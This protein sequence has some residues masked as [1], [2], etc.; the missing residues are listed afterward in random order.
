MNYS[1]IIKSMI[2]GQIATIIFL[3]VGYVVDKHINPNISNVIALI[4]GGIANYFMQ[5]IVFKSK[6]KFN[7]STI[8]KFIIVD[9]MLYTYEELSFIYFH[10]KFPNNTLARLVIATIGFVFIS[11]PLRKFYAF[12][13]NVSIIPL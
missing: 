9:V 7:S 13:N 1:E 12:N 2:G 4:C 3:I 8:T 11:F 10:D 6:N 5:S